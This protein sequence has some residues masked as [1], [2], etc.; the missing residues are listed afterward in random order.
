L[1][2]NSK[3]LDRINDLA[4]NS[5]LLGRAMHVAAASAIYTIAALAVAE[6]GLGP[7]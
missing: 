2:L 6:R 3:I 1:D 7:A 4:G 5:S